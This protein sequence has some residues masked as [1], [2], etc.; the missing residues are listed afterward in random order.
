MRISHDRRRD[1][2][3]WIMDWMVK[4]TGRVI[5]FEYDEREVPPYVRNYAQVPRAMAKLGLAKERMADAAAS[6]GR[7][8]T[9]LHTYYKAIRNYHTAQHAIFEDDSAPKIEYHAR[10]LRCF[11]RIMELSDDPIER[12]EVPWDGKQIQGNLHLIPGAPKAPCVIFLPGM[13]MV[14][15]IVPDPTDNVFTSRGMHCLSIDGPG[16]GMSNIRKIR[17]TADNYEHAVSAVIDYLETRPEVDSDKIALVGASMGSYWGVR[18]A[19]LDS[20][21][22][23]VAVSMSNMGSK[24]AIFEQ[25]SPRF[26]QIF[27]YMAGMS[28]E[29]EFD[30]MAAKMSTDGYAAKIT[31][32]F[33]LVAGEYDPLSP[34]EDIEQFFDELAGPKEL[35]AL[36]DFYHMI[37]DPPH[38]GNIS[39]YHHMS[40]WI[41]A[42]LAGEMEPSHSKYVYFGP[43][44]LGPYTEPSDLRA[45]TAPLMGADARLAA[46]T[47]SAAPA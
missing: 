29:D 19:A 7:K 33:L 12:V 40:D 15:E 45:S 41:V 4:T 47:T 44:D 32:P 46:E 22:K 9:A 16:Q 37:W 5:N 42:A 34:I 28:D 14:K 18:S 25:A 13:D 31:C 38:F 20:R 10:L 36:A 6:A 3:Q 30:A 39:A 27:M 1:N 8:R 2:Q 21:I 17:V 26:K 35:W 43:N 23:A 24:T 11:D